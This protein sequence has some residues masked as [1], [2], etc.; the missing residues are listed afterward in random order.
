MTT[1]ISIDPK[2]YDNLMDMTETIPKNVLYPYTILDLSLPWFPSTFY[3]KGNE[4]N[5][6]SALSIYPSEPSGPC[7]VLVTKT[8]EMCSP[9]WE[10]HESQM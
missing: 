1:F 6:F 7:S 10:D 5:I 3:V 4:I 9:A 2:F 8:I